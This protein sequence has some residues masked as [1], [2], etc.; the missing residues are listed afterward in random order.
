MVTTLFIDGM[1]SVHC[2]RA[3]F[4]ALSGVEGI[5][6]AEVTMGE[7]RIEHERELAEAEIAARVAELGYSVRETVT[8]RRRLTIRSDDD[9]SSPA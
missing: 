2:V 6:S 1:R 3:V 4:T 9:F 7:V 8:Q 5:A